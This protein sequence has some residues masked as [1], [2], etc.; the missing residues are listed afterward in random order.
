LAAVVVSTT[1]AAVGRPVVAEFALE[2]A[3]VATVA[4]AD[5]AE[6]VATE[7]VA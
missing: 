4:A 2:G 1:A 6:V 5:V 7:N 3:A